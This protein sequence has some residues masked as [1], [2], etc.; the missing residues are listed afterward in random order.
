MDGVSS[1]PENPEGT[2]DMARISPSPADGSPTAWAPPPR[3]DQWMATGWRAEGP[4]KL[5][6]TGLLFAATIVH[7]VTIP[8]ALMLT[9]LY[10]ESLVGRTVTWDDFFRAWNLAGLG[11]ISLLLVMNRCSI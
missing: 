9:K 2:E 4:R 10:L 3:E 6:G 11:F 5:P 8:I 7:L 1:G